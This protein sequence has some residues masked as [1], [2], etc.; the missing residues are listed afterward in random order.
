MKSFFFK[1]YLANIFFKKVLYYNFISLNIL[2]ATCAHC[3]AYAHIHTHA[4]TYTLGLFK[5]TWFYFLANFNFEKILN[6]K[7][8]KLCFWYIQDLLRYSSKQNK[9]IWKLLHQ[10]FFYILMKFIKMNKPW[11]KTKNLIINKQL[12]RPTQRASILHCV[13]NNIQIEN[14]PGRNQTSSFYSVNLQT[15]LSCDYFYFLSVSIVGLGR[16]GKTFSM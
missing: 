3:V 2:E 10:I 11:N 7:S 9:S 12:Y 15:Q 13:F 14:L 4:H 5:N 1:A 8:S 16:R 6:L